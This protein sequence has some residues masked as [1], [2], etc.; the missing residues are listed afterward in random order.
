[1]KK[2][3][4]NIGHILLII[5]MFTTFSG[6]NNE[7]D[8]IKIFTGKTWKLSFIATEGSI[9]QFDFWNGNESA[10][11]NSMQALKNENNFILNFDGSN[12]SGITGGGFN[13]RGIITSINGS[14]RANGETN[15]LSIA[16]EGS[17]T[18]NDVLG[19]AF[20]TGLKNAFHYRGDE[21][22]LYIYYKEGQT[23]KF[24]AFS[25]YKSK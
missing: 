18:E 8:V 21:N 15:E 22:N 19:Q 5:S 9:K 6:C 11:N 4:K 25:P 24:L 12:L 20:I 17:P 23:T 16:I 2:A 10:Y 3:I 7:D 13:G 14:W 1:M